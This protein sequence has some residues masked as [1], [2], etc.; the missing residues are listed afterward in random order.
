MR[1]FIICLLILIVLSAKAQVITIRDIATKQPI[2]NVILSTGPTEKALKPNAKGQFDV[3]KVT[4]A[5]SIIIKSP[6]YQPQM[7]SFSQIK[8][9]KFTV[10]LKKSDIFLDA[11]VISSSRSRQ[12][13][14]DVPNK[15]TTLEQK[16]II[17]Q[18]PQTTADLLGQSGEV[19][20]QKSQMS[21]GS[22]MI[23]GFATN[24]GW[25]KNEYCY[26]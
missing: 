2:T 22:P 25:C 7:L 24:R 6:G 21:G 26:I 13:K 20:I 14:R 11:V 4:E 23:R 17:F 19:Y 16:D 9:M 5:E 12:N 18:N 1:S 15:I 10:Y 8:A 3:Y